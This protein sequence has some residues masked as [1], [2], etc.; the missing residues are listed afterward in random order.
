[1][2][3]LVSKMGI[4]FSISLQKMLRFIVVAC[5]VVSILA[6][7]FTNENLKGASAASSLVDDAPPA[8]AS[9]S[10]GLIRFDGNDDGYGLN[11]DLH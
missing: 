7:D 3:F 4:S 2:I 1:M 9:S 8:A 11:R 6:D 10:G 5:I